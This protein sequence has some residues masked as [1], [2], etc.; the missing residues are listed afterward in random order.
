MSLIFQV[1]RP[2]FETGGRSGF[3]FTPATLPEGIGRAGWYYRVV[4]GA[5]PAP[6]KI[7]RS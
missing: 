2:G 7:R 3:L 5:K 1:A 4:A 6:E